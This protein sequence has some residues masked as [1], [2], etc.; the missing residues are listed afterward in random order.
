MEV[1]L[2]KM[3]KNLKKLKKSL[4]GVDFS[5]FYSQSLLKITFFISF[6]PTKII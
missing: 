2:G 3:E 4:T 6:I 5:F 1:M